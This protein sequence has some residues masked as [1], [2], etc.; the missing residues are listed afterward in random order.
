[1]IA[2]LFS[3]WNCNFL[4]LFVDLVLDRHSLREM[5]GSLCSKGSFTNFVLRRE[6]S[7]F[8]WEHFF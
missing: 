6:S 7:H 1:M 2:L 3:K 5:W 4:A 8:P